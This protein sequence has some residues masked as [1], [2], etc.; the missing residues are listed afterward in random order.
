M[1]IYK[2]PEGDFQKVFAENQTKIIK[3]LKTAS[4]FG[5]IKQSK[6]IKFIEANGFYKRR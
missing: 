2:C 6:L 5:T 4:T 3:A 1:P